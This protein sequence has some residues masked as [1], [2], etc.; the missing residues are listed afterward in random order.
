MPEYKVTVRRAKKSKKKHIWITC[1]LCKTRSH[2]R[3]HNWDGA[4][5]VALGHAYGKQH[6]KKLKQLKASLDLA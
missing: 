2:T 5:K 1:S 6:I 3:K 4:M